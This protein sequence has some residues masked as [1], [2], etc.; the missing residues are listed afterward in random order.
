MKLLMGVLISLT[1][2]SG[3][4]DYSTLNQ[5]ILDSNVEKLKGY[6]AAMAACGSDAACKVGVSMA[7]ATN[8]GQQQLF[9]PQTALDWAA[10]LSPYANTLLE[11]YKIH[12]GGIGSGMGGIN[13]NGSNGVS[14]SGSMSEL[15]S[16]GDGGITATFDASSNPS[17]ETGTRKYNLGATGG[18]VTD[19]GIVDPVDLTGE[20]LPVGTEPLTVSED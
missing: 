4:A 17:W 13:I 3:C 2:L 10:A 15:T 7:Y 9:K 6:G 16:T 1:L 11:V 19:T 20:P 5:Q 8:V 18:T 12:E 14:I